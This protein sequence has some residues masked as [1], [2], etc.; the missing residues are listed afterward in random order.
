MDLETC[1]YACGWEG[2]D[3]Q[4]VENAEGARLCPGCAAEEGL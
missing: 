2:P 3:E 4:L 1:S